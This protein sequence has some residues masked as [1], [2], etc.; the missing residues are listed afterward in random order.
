MSTIKELKLTRII[1]APRELV[2]Q[3]W[4]DPAQFAQWW[5]P[6]CFT[7]PVCKLDTRPGGKILVHMT[8]PDGTVYPMGGMF[9]E[10]TPPEKIVM[11]TTSFRDDKNNEQIENLNTIL[12]TETSDGKTQLALHVVVL[13]ATPEMDGALSGM[14]AGWSQSFEKLNTLLSQV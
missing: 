13:K 8:A 12:F 6:G 3:A 2:F 14:E 10:I 7:N 1:N 5:G 9:H 11:T 4:I